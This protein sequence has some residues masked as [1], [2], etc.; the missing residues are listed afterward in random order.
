M[1]IS[2]G[3]CRGLRC[4]IPLELKFQV[5]VSHLIWVVELD[6]KSLEEWY[7]RLRAEP[8]VQPPNHS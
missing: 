4:W 2:E 6:S 3:A 8:F 1:H 5:I 7:R